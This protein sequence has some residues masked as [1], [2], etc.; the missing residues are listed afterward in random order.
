MPKESLPLCNKPLWLWLSAFYGSLLSDFSKYMQLKI[1]P[2]DV[3]MCLDKLNEAR[4][5]R[6]IETPIRGSNIR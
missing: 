4:W 2:I 1:Q 6:I 3:E 5:G